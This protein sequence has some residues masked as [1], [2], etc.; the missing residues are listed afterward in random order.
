MSEE[1]C[2]GGVVGSHLVI[3][4]EGGL[5]E[6]ELG[7]APVEVD[8][9]HDREEAEPQ[10]LV[11]EGGALGGLEFGQVQFTREGWSLRSQ[12]VYCLAVHLFKCKIILINDSF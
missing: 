11:A 9:P 6:A 3:L 5:S 7:D 8:H 4:L 10:D 1:E 12:L 2:L